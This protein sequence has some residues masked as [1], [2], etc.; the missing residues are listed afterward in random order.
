M[1]RLGPDRKVLGI[2]LQRR[3]L[4]AGTHAARPR[5]SRRL[6][7]AEIRNREV[8]GARAAGAARDG[9]DGL[10]LRKHQ[11]WSWPGLSRPFYK[12]PTKQDV[13]A[14]GAQTIVRSLR[15]KQTT[16]P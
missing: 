1:L 9:D 10:R 16:M 14:R 3:L 7:P 13:D 6:R 2:Y 12:K 15:K 5:H 4:L 8:V 11:R